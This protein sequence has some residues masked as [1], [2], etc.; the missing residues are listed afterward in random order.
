[1]PEV[2][3]QITLTSNL[4]GTVFTIG[5][6]VSDVKATPRGSVLFAK[7]RFKDRGDLVVAE[8]GVQRGVNA[9]YI[10]NELRPK[11]LVLVDS[12]DASSGQMNNLNFA[13]TWHRLHGK[14]EIIFIKGWSADVSRIVDLRF[15]FIYIDGDH[16]E[17]MVKNDLLSWSPKVKPGGLIGGHDFDHPAGVAKAVRDM[18]GDRVITRVDGKKLAGEDWMVLYDL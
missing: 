13:E 17:S 3:K 4:S 18:F 12:W 6:D 14:R 16:A 11:L 1:M 8:I 5:G 7:D 10:W 2:F 15:D 9:E